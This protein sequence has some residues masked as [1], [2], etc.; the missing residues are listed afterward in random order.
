MFC[1]PY[2]KSYLKTE[3]RGILSFGFLQ[4]CIVLHHSIVFMIITCLYKKMHFLSFRFVCFFCVFYKASLTTSHMPNSPISVVTFQLGLLILSW[5]TTLFG[6]SPPP[7]NV[8]FPSFCSKK[9]PKLQKKVIF[10]DFCKNRSFS[11]SNTRIFS[12]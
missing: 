8:F 4:N 1:H 2:N 5:R 10:S 12:F 3:V 6:V 7:E 11:F 9:C